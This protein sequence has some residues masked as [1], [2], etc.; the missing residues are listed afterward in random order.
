MRLKTTITMLGTAM[1]I[2]FASQASATDPIE[3]DSGNRYDKPRYYNSEVSVAEAYLEMH[4]SKGHDK[5]HKHRSQPV[6]I[7]VRRLREYAAGHPEKAYNVP[8]PHKINNRDQ[9]AAD[10]YWGVYEV[11]KGDYDRPI[12]LLCRTGSR[13]VDAGNILANPDLDAGT[14]GLPAF[15][16]VRNIWEGFVGNPKYAY[17]GNDIK[18][19]ADGNPIPL[20][21]N[22]DGLVT[23]DDV[24]D[25]YEETADANPDK[26]GWRNFAALPWSTKI[27]RSLAYNND[28]WQYQAFMTPVVD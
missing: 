16:N 3:T 24:A 25:V 14:E 2:G 10:L 21:L 23:F 20:D 19:D 27:R 22:N 17:S 8:Y 26:D 28:V 18:F 5:R 9:T 7:D 4:H 6:L 13:S 15:T 1:A 11:V 12:M